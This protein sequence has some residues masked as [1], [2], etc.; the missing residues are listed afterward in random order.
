MGRLYS[1]NL[2]AHRGAILKVQSLGFI[3]RT[4]EFYAPESRKYC[5]KLYIEDSVGRPFV[6]NEFCHFDVDC[7]YNMATAWLNRMFD[8]LSYWK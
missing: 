1:G 7:L 2:N 6:D 3:V 8:Q 4:V 5:M